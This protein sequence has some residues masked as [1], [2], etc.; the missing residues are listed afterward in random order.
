MVS[1]FYHSFGDTHKLMHMDHEYESVY[2]SGS[3]SF[4]VEIS[5]DANRQVKSQCLK[6]AWTTFFGPVKL[7]YNSFKGFSNML[8]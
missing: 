6:M 1:F 3:N 8:I 7:G 4:K 2:E 5:F